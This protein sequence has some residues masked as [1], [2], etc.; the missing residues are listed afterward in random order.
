MPYITEQILDKPNTPYMTKE[1]IVHALEVIIK[2][3]LNK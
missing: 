3:T 2:T 1:M